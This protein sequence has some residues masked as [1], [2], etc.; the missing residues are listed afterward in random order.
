MLIR[1]DTPFGAIGFGDL[2]R[3]GREMAV[4]AVRAS[5]DVSADGR[6]RLADTQE[7][8]LNDVYEGDPQRT[9][10]L[11]VGDLVPFRP[12][13]DITALG[14]AYPPGDRSAWEVGIAVG[15]HEAT[16]RVHGP[17]Q[18]EP[19]LKF[20]KPDWKLGQGG[21][22]AGVRLDY[23]LASGGC[24]VGDGEG[25]Y[26]SRNPI[27]PGL[28]CRDI[29]QVGH[30]LRAPQID[31]AMAPVVDPFGQ[32]EPQGFGPVPPFWS[33]RE[34][35]LGTRDEAWQ[36][37]RKPQMPSD[38][39]YLFF[40]AAHPNLTVPV[41]RGNEH[42]RLTGLIPGGGVLAFVLPSVALVA[43]H[44]WMD[45][46]ETTGRLTLDGLHLDLRAHNEP[47]RVDLTWRSWIKR[48]HGYRGARL[49]IAPFAASSLLPSYTENGLVMTE[50]SA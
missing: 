6:L 31:S 14:T 30:P 13:A 43:H 29:S 3:D 38:F 10:L 2:H 21:P 27:G 37:E 34:R 28:L 42:V 45:G 19:M 47:W 20:L 15:F 7:V 48:D 25:R 1:N 5:Y 24:Y 23:R 18:W 49:D 41:L 46:R 50:A 16:L 17:R 12:Y 9:P 39:S 11:K 40:Q 35:H 22:V 4:I 8:F 26:D 44:S 36:R 32:P 33:W